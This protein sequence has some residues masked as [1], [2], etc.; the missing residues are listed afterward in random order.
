MSAVMSQYKGRINRIV[1]K[2]AESYELSQND[3]EFVNLINVKE[4]YI[5]K[6]LSISTDFET[7]ICSPVRQA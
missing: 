1:L 5:I 3:S 2:I 7:F 4:L 6:H